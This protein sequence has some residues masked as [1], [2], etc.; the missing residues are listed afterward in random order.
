MFVFIDSMD[1]LYTEFVFC[2][3]DCRSLSSSLYTSRPRYLSGLDCSGSESSLL[4]CSY[5]SPPGT[6]C[7]GGAGVSVFCS[8]APTQAPTEGDHCTHPSYILYMVTLY[9]YSNKSSCSCSPNYS[10]IGCSPYDFGHNL[11]ILDCYWTGHWP[12]F[13]EQLLHCHLDNRTGDHSLHCWWHSCHGH[14]STVLLPHNLV[15]SLLSSQVRSEIL[16]QLEEPVQI[17]SVGIIL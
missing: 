2:K 8:Q 5:T 16:F 3:I 1:S 9:Y 4:S 14:W 7:S 11:W 13:K 10:G 15:F 6:A 17:F 12:P